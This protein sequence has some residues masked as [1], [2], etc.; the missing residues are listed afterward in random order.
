MAD[1][2][3]ARAF[4]MI[5]LLIVIAIIAVLIALLLPAVQQAR[6]AARRAQCCNNL[7]QIGLALNN[8]HDAH[9]CFPPL[10][11]GMVPD[12]RD[13]RCWPAKPPPTYWGW[14][15]MILPFLDEGVLYN[16]CNFQLDCHRHP[17]NR[18][19]KCDVLQQLMCPSDY[20]YDEHQSSYMANCGSH[21][22]C[23]RETP[24]C[25]RGDEVRCT[26][27]RAGFLLNGLSTRLLDMTDGRARTFAVGERSWSRLN[28]AR[29][30]LGYAPLGDGRQTGN[31]GKRG[32]GLRNEEP[33]VKSWVYG[34]TTTGGTW[35]PLGHKADAN[36]EFA[37]GSHHAGGAHFL[38][39]D[40]GVTFISHTI[41]FHVY[42]ALSTIAGNELV[43][44][45]DY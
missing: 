11:I 15:P 24:A 13:N 14:A 26:V 30:A 29:R 7:L 12:E 28:E 1:R 5:E 17:A 23:R 41:D 27:S 34:L 36:A 44:D 42:Q 21:A 8:Y 40:G 4:T 25:P 10:A 6:E 20:G 3:G 19:V 37:F 2:R 43:D 9:R 16:A 18:T 38:F 31:G 22:A 35:V 45:D 32:P 33:D 39:V